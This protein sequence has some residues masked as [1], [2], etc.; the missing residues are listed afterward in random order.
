MQLQTQMRGA[1]TD[2][3]WNQRL[4]PSLLLGLNP[5]APSRAQG[6]ALP[7]NT[8]AGGDH[9]AVP[10]SPD[11]PLFWLGGVVLLTV[12]GVTGASVRVRAFSKRA[13]V[14]LGDD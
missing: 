2:M 14:E 9:V 1:P 5:G 11:S 7:P 12:L 13:S 6:A 4:T 3:Y 8:A 10:W